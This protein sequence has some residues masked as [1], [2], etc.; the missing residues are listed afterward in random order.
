MNE[1][2]KSQPQNLKKELKKLTLIDCG[3]NSKSAAD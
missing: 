1:R 3:K 2:T